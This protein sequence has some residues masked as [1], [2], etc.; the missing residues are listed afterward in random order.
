MGKNWM[1]HTGYIGFVKHHDSKLSKIIAWFMKSRWSHTFLVLGEM[2]GV[3]IASETSDFHVNYAPIDRYFKDPECEIAIYAIDL[4]EGEKDA[5]VECAGNHYGETYGY[6]QLLSFAI[7][8]ALAKIG[9][10]I[11]NFFRQ[12]LVCTAVPLYAFNDAGLPHFKDIAP[13]SIHTE[14]LFQLVSSKYKLSEMK[15]RGVIF[16]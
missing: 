15:N 14:E 10:K 6:L 7:R 3:R 2:R 5:I 4:N 9:I 16:K 13:E 12:G 11:P 8:A 1:I